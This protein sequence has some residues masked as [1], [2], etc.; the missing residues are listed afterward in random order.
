MEPTLP[1]SPYR[2]HDREQRVFLLGLAMDCLAWMIPAK[3]LRVRGAVLL[4]LYND[5]SDP[6]WKALKKIV[7]KTEIDWSELQTR[8]SSIVRFRGQ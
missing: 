8:A 5:R 7:A 6:I 3:D 2:G 1:G 4:G